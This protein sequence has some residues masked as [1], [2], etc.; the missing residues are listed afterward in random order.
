[1][2]QI[3]SKRVTF[4]E[5]GQT[6]GLGRSKTARSKSP[7]KKSTTQFAGDSVESSRGKSTTFRSSKEARKLLIRNCDRP[8]AK[9]FVE[10]P[11]IKPPKEDEHAQP[12]RAVAVSLEQLPHTIPVMQSNLDTARKIKELS[13]MSLDTAATH[14]KE[15]RISEEEVLQKVAAVALNVPS[16]ERQFSNLVSVDFPESQVIRRPRSGF[17][18]S[19]EKV[20]SSPCLDHYLTER[21]ANTKVWPKFSPI[22]ISFQP[23]DLYDGRS[24]LKAKH[25]LQEKSKLLLS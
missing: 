22:S 20:D 15:F 3:S 13:E 25:L 17:V 11:T 6:A 23:I 7:S 19:R 14:I 12:P 10:R 8:S 1:M 24:V 5:R 18:K 9:P 4:S 21:P 16:S 2:S